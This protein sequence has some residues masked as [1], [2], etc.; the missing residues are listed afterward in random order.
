MR[1]H[2]LTTLG[3]AAGISLALC[4]YLIYVYAPLEVHMGIVQKIFYT[5][6]PLA[7][8]SFVS[9]FVVFVASI[10]YL[11]TRNRSWDNL[12]GAAAEVGLLFSG[13]ALVTGSIW[14]R[15]SWGVWWTW[16]PPHHNTCHVVCLCRL[17]STSFHE[18]TS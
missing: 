5:H 2:W 16:D 8:W 3:L 12:A 15:H 7:W 1:T 18:S 13:L 11:R 14:G 6:L 17:L 9:F 4:Q 10:A